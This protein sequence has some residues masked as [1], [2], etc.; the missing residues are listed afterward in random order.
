MNGWKNEWKT[1]Y[2]TFNKLLNM[3]YF[4]LADKMQKLRV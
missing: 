1:Q 3:H 2:L 4:S